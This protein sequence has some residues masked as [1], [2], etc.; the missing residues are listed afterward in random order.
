[1]PANATG[2]SE[3]AGRQPDMH[4]GAAAGISAITSGML[5]FDP[6]REEDGLSNRPAW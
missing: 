5:L 2:R 4:G 6:L 1:M 3:R